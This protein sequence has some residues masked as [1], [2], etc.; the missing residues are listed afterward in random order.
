MNNYLNTFR[1]SIISW[2]ILCE[3]PTGNKITLEGL[4]HRVLLELYDKLEPFIES[5]DGA[6]ITYNIMGNL[7]VIKY[8][9]DL[10]LD[11]END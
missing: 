6:Y 3:S 5:R 2:L 1:E 9:L 10:L 8:P 11:D 7:I 4:D